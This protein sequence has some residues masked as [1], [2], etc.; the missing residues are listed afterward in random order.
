VDVLR[1]AGP[2]RASRE[3]GDLALRRACGAA[4][5]GVGQEQRAGEVRGRVSLGEGA[6][7]AARAHAGRRRVLVA[8]REGGDAEG[9]RRDARARGAE[10][11]AAGRAEQWH[12]GKWA[13]KSDLEVE[14]GTLHVLRCV[15]RH[16]SPPRAAIARSRACEAQ[17]RRSRRSSASA[18][19]PGAPA[20]RRLHSSAGNEASPLLGSLGGRRESVIALRIVRVPQRSAP[21]YARPTSP[22]ES[23]SSKSRPLAFA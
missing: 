16:G 18:S 17:I 9:V 6:K 20:A 2:L 3:E 5:A 1:R 7:R 22:S 11:A 21:S 14:A 12:G 19:K 23:S 4:V 8:P 15:S 10:R 13:M